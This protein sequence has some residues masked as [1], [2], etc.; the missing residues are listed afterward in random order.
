MY[1]DVTF[2]IE[3]HVPSRSPHRFRYL[4]IYRITK[5]WLIRNTVLAIP[6]KWLVYFVS[7]FIFYVL[8]T[9]FFPCFDFIRSYFWWPPD[10]LFLKADVEWFHPESLQD[11]NFDSKPIFFLEIQVLLIIF[12][13]RWPKS[14]QS[15]I[16]NKIN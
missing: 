2:C 5:K 12:N 13:D 14:G 7:F 4:P 3:I 15:M 8:K 10:K 6:L 16:F 9:S 11:Q 1:L